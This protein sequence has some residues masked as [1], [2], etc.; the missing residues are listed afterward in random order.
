MKKPYAKNQ[1]ATRQ[2]LSRLDRQEFREKVTVGCEFEGLEQ[3]YPEINESKRY[4]DQK[5]GILNEI[6]VKYSRRK[7]ETGTINDLRNEFGLEPLGTSD[8]KIVALAAM[9][10]E[11]REQRKELKPSKNTQIMIENASWQDILNEMKSDVVIANSLEIMMLHKEADKLIEEYKGKDKVDESSDNN[12]SFL[13]GKVDAF[14][15]KSVDNIF[16]RPAATGKIQ[17]SK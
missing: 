9:E 11:Q 14:I 1:L 7:N 13:S 2:I 4:I 6:S 10:R 15:T 3:K 8:S 5:T 12:I 16:S 17:M